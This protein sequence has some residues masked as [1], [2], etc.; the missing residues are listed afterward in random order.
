V[1]TRSVTSVR[2]K[3]SRMGRSL[4]KKSQINVTDLTQAAL[5]HV[6]RHNSGLVCPACG[7]RLVATP[8][9]LCGVCHKQAL[10]EA[11]RES[12]AEL[13]AHRD[14]NVAKQDLSRARKKAGVRASK[15]RVMPSET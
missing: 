1:L 2:M 15:G 13:T 9:G 5:D 10:A 11:H 6:K 14:Y 4:K 12:L 7:A 8:S 3:A